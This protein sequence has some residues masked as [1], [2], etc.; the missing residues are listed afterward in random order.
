MVLTARIALVDMTGHIED[1]ELARVATVLDLQIK[2]DLAQFWPV[3]ATVSALTSPI[4][5]PTGVWPVY[6]VPTLDHDTAG[7]HSS[8]HNQPYVEVADGPS[9]SLAASHEIMEM[10][11]DPGGNRLLAAPAISL[12]ENGTVRDEPGVLEYLLEI[13][14]PSE[15]PDFAYLI[16]D[17]VVSDFYTPHFFD[18]RPIPGTRYSF[19]GAL[20]APRRVCKGGYMSWWNARTERMERLDHTQPGK[21]PEIIEIG[22]HLPNVSLREFADRYKRHRIRLSETEPQHPILASSRQRAEHLRRDAYAHAT[23]FRRRP[24]H[25]A[26]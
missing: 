19:T 16:D 3:S 1:A 10:L 13:C 23:H 26:E 24:R 12:T 20:K 18:S 14:D 6:V 17:V 8:I 21:P 7:F 5:I 2:R 15:G 25:I 4:C 9:W 22:R 11:V